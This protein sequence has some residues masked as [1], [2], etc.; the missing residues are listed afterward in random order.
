M[1]IF[2]LISI[3]F[4]SFYLDFDLV[5]LVFLFFTFSFVVNL[6]KL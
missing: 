3:S 1:D 4:S 2:A 5:F 6:A